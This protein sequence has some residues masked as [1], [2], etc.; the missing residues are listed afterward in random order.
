MRSLHL[1]FGLNDP[2]VV[3]VG[4]EGVQDVLLVLHPWLKLLAAVVEAMETQCLL[5]TPR[6]WLQTQTKKPYFNLERQ[7]FTSPKCFTES[8]FR[9][10]F[11]K[12]FQ[13]TFPM[14]PLS[15]WPGCTGSCSPGPGWHACSPQCLSGTEGLAA[16]LSGF[17]TCH[18]ASSGCASDDSASC[19]GSLQHCWWRQKWR[20]EPEESEEETLALTLL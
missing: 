20:E 3:S 19:L 8:S 6:L 4:A 11:K 7:I 16:M 12:D 14:L 1:V 18:D 10:Y 9:L 2:Q 15:P 5:Q 17:Q 13:A